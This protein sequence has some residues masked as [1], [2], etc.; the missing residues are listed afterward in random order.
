MR[1]DETRHLTPE[2]LAQDKRDADTWALGQLARQAAGLCIRW[3]HGER[4]ACIL[5]FDHLGTCQDSQGNTTL[6]ITRELLGRG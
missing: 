4:D 3:G 6:S 1:D 5:P 2:E